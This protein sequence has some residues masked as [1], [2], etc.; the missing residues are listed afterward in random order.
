MTRLL[1]FNPG[2]R[3]HVLADLLR[4][5]FGFAPAA[6]LVGLTIAVIVSYFK[7]WRIARYREARAGLLPKHVWLIGTSYLIILAD[8]IFSLI[9]RLHKP[10]TPHTF[11]VLPGYVLG[12]MALHTILKFERLRYESDAANCRDLGPTDGT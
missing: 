4:V 7:A 9:E 8:S 6:L 12:C 5:F 2:D 3:G 10:L 11:I 1:E